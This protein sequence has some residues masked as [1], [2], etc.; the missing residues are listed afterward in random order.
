[1]VG[2]SALSGVRRTPAWAKLIPSSCTIE[3]LPP[4]ANEPVTLSS[5]V[6][7]KGAVLRVTGE[8]QAAPVHNHGPLLKKPPI[9]FP[10][11]GEVREN[12]VVV[13]GAVKVTVPIRFAPVWSGLAT[14]PPIGGLWEA[15]TPGLAAVP[16]P[17]PF[18][19]IPVSVVPEIGR[20]FAGATAAA[21][22]RATVAR[23]SFFI[24]F[25]PFLCCFGGG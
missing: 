18:Q 20:A 19:I 24:N 5:V 14:S 12:G 10:P 2:L 9:V 21:K 8:E 6:V 16:P 15:W 13:F 7:A 22:P 4:V 23:S 1:V 17:L 11:G 3:P 25:T